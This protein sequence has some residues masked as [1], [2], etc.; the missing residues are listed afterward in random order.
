MISTVSGAV[1]EGDAT[2]EAQMTRFF[3]GKVNHR[4][5]RVG[6]YCVMYVVEGGSTTAV[7]PR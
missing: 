7:R 2:I 3:A 6:A 4:R 5:L 1:P